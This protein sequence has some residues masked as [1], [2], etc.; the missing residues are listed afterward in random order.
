[1]R[2]MEVLNMVSLSSAASN[3]SFN[4]ISPILTER[5]AQE[6]QTETSDVGKDKLLQHRYS[7]HLLG[8]HST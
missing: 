7:H 2:A 3:N 6:K 8:T 4:F 5:K 1:M